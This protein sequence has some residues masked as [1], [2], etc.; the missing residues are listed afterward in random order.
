MEKEIK[1]LS[2]KEF[3]YR[4]KYERAHI[5]WVNNA[6]KLRAFKQALKEF[7]ERVRTHS[8]YDAK[9]EDIDAKSIDELVKKHFGELIE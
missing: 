7:T 9:Y 1:P 6:K 8:S 5:G 4:C 3:E 2:E